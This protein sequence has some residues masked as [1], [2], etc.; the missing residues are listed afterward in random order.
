M[1]DG[2]PLP[3]PAP[4]IAPGAPALSV[5][6][7]CYDT[8]P[9]I[10]AALQSVLD[11]GLERPEIVV[12]DDGSSDATAE[13]AAGV[14][15][16]NRDRARWVPILL[17]ANTPGGVGA[18][19][20]L[21]V[22]AATGRHLAFLDGDDWLDPVVLPEA[23]GRLQA[24]GADMLVTDCVD[25]IAPEGRLA[26]YAEEA[27]WAAA[28]AAWDPV[29]RRRALLRLAP[30][31]WRK[32][33]DRGFLE[34]EGIA[35]PVG[36]FFFEDNVHHWEA[37]LAA[38]RTALLRKR[39]HAH[40]VGAP[41]QTIAGRGRKFL[42]IFEH[43][44]AI[45]AILRRRD[46]QGRHAPEFADWLVRHIWWAM[47]RADPGGLFAFWDAARGCVAA[48]DPALLDR[49]L[50]GAGLPARGAALTACVLAGDRAAFAAIWAQSGA[51]K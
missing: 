9:W 30:M 1:P 4:A 3:H 41:G 28:E 17:A 48:H 50:Q 51:A 35:F 32:L 16:R 12:V 40:R 44:R 29:A 46:P 47:E 21:G 20:N 43:H 34:R 19:A 45:A 25:F 37:V 13:V 33:Y 23:L 38:R 42:A 6:V 49:A 8:A 2:A 27:E 14:I 5:V 26:P 15:R 24:S 7:T 39:L 36:D 31:P 10:A 11:A 18:A 22:E